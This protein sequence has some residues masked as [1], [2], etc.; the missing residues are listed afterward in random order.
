[1]NFSVREKLGAPTES[2]PTR[3]LNLKFLWGT[4]GQRHCTAFN[5][6]V[7]PLGDKGGTQV[8]PPLTP[9]MA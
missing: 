5:L 9:G 1:M 6:I 2:L 4:G 3:L 8:Y 7:E